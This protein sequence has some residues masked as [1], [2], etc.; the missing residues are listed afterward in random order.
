[1]Q[2]MAP[3]SN[4]S[5][6]HKIQLQTSSVRLPSPRPPSRSGGCTHSTMGGPGCICLPTDR[7]L[8][9]SGGET[10]GFPVPEHYSDCS[11]VA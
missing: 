2:E 8:G 7:H 1:M 5:V 10:T 9:Q 4:R 11:R 3:A 6:C